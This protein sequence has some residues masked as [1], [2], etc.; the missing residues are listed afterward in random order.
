MKTTIATSLLA[1]LSVSVTGLPIDTS[2][3]LTLG[4]REI[5]G[6]TSNQLGNCAPVTVIFARGTVEPGNIGLLAGPP[7]FDI[8]AGL[9][10][11]GNLAVQG[12]PYS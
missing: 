10:G 8:L 2:A 6:D 11:A 1:L 5:F 4:K 7:F 9:I 3:A 12:V